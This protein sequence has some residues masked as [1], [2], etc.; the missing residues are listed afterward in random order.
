MLFLRLLLVNVPEATSFEFLR[1]VDDLVYDSYQEAYCELQ[2]LEDDNQRDMV[3]ESLTST[4]NNIRQLFAIILT[5]YSTQSLTLWEKYKNYMTKDILNR[6]RQK[7]RWPTKDFT[8]EM[9][10]EALL[11]VDLCILI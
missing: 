4:P 1:T 9:Y 2:L 11:Q 3:L 6:V 8:P 10:N 7:E 5:F